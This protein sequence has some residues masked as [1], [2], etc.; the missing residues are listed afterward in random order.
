MAIAAR[1]FPDGITFCE[2]CERDRKHHRVSGRK[3]FACDTCGNHTYPLVGTIFQKSSTKLRLWLYAM[4]LMASTRCGISAK[5]VQRECGVTYKCA[6]RMFKQ[7][8]SLLSEEFQLEGSCRDF[9]KAI[10]RRKTSRE[11]WRT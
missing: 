9:N 7:I 6:W 11:T 1:R 2:V 8:R 10:F 4:Y 5:Q 3:A